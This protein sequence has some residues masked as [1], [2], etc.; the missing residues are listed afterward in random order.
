MGGV[1]EGSVSIS[2]T[3]RLCKKEG[4]QRSLQKRILRRGKVLVELR[5][6]SWGGLVGG[7]YRGDILRAKGRTIPEESVRSPQIRGR[8]RK[9]ETKKKTVK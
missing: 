1:S 2:E 9:V 6:I 4:T 3:V 5:A 8:V 7:E